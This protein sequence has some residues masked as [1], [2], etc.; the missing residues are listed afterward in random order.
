MLK[1]SETINDPVFIKATTFH[2]SS[3]EEGYL[4]CVLWDERVENILVKSLKK[5]KKALMQY[6]ETLAKNVCW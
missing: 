1:A 5:K 4:S 3:L 6:Y 2:T